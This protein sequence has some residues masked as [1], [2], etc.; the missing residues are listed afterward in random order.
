MNGALA[1]IV[2]PRFTNLPHSL[3]QFPAWCAWRTGDKNSSGKFA[4]RPTVCGK[5]NYSRKQ[6]QYD[7]KNWGDVTQAWKDYN[8]GNPETFGGIGVCVNFCDGYSVLDIDSAFHRGKL[9][10]TVRE[11]LKRIGPAYTEYS[12]SG[13]GLHLWFEGRLD[14]DQ[15]DIGSRPIGDDASIELYSGSGLRF[16]TV[17][18]EL[19]ASSA[20]DIIPPPDGL[21][22][23]LWAQYGGKPKV[24]VNIPELPPPLDPLEFAAEFVAITGLLYKT[25]KETLASIATGS[26][27]ST[28]SDDSD[29]STSGLLFSLWN[30]LWS[31]DEV[32]LNGLLTENQR[33]EGIDVDCLLWSWVRQQP[34]VMSWVSGANREKG[35]KR[36]EE[37]ADLFIWSDFQRAK[38]KR[39]GLSST[40]NDLTAGDT[41]SPSP[42]PKPKTK[43][44]TNVD[45]EEEPFA[46][47][48]FEWHGI[49]PPALPEF[50][51]KN[52]IPRSEV[53][54]LSGIGGVGKSWLSLQLMAAVALGVDW[55]GLGTSQGRV[56]GVFTEETHAVLNYRIEE[57]LM[58]TQFGA[59]AATV[60]EDW[61]HT[62]LRGLSDRFFAAPNAERDIQR[63]T[64]M[65]D[66]IDH[67][68]TTKPD[69]IVLDNLSQIFG[70]NEISKLESTW[71]I[72]QLCNVADE[73][74]AAI[75]LL[76]H[77]SESGIK[78]GNYTSGSRG[79]HNT[80]R[81]QIVL[82]YGD[83][84]A[85]DEPL[86][87]L[88][89]ELAKANHA[90]GDFPRKVELIK[91]GPLFQ[92][93]QQ[94]E[95]ESLI[96]DIHFTKLKQ[97]YL[98]LETLT[99][100]VAENLSMAPNSTRYVVRRVLAY[101]REQGTTVVQSEVKL[102]LERLHAQGC[103]ATGEIVGGQM[104]DIRLLHPPTL[105]AAVEA[106]A[107]R[108]RIAE[109]LS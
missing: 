72:N 102:A 76:S 105:K 69:L 104:N 8:A 43:P 75:V 67:A 19:F 81:S 62:T 99:K 35:Q 80:I 63:T 4:K 73:I 48:A 1:D 20:E 21:L 39:V 79:F 55:L 45:P 106:D 84:N 13:N 36:N 86:D 56:L 83:R 58:R 57:V 66:F 49:H 52:W 17:T 40:F 87:S 98:T 11:L 91:N 82:R 18:G 5:G 26:K 33:A 89:L 31:L 70:G 23:K 74:N 60:G 64:L 46:R 37:D 30:D 88:Y 42:S 7:P 94:D 44:E 41:P 61:H 51:V 50:V 107:E 100:G 71:F 38:L 101:L 85:E 6:E 108:V 92:S 25:T 90:S 24:D 28:G 97:V 53:T 10:P 93:D 29:H 27:V 34:G 103:I 9:K 95:G 14:E 32:K 109:I 96:E 2:R 16:M 12:P 3:K 15:A 78:S 68:L 22:Q 54:L 77:P 65:L 47:T 59:T